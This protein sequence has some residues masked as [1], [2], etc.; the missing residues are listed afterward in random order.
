[1]YNYSLLGLLLLVTVGLSS[2]GPELV[3]EQKH[4]MP[5]HWTYADSVQFQY[6]IQDTSRAY[7][8]VLTVEHTDIFPTQNL[9]TKFVTIYPNGL[10][11]TEPVNL[12]LADR[13]GQWLGDCT[14]ESCELRLPLQQGA[15]YPEAGAYGLTIH[16]FGR[17]DSLQALNG[18]GLE[19]YVA[20][21]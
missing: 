2:C 5:G 10:R 9:Y 1:M 19:I 7:D 15:K 20:S 13:F 8:L 21:K 14:G 16:Q 12:E 18:F 6:E 11:N 3:S 17:Q 4:P